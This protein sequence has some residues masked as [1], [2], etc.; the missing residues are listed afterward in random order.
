MN[1]LE[2]EGRLLQIKERKLIDSYGVQSIVVEKIMAKLETKDICCFSGIF[3]AI[4]SSN[5]K[6]A[7]SYILEL[8][9]ISDTN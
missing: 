1:S 5:L 9:Y 7:L 8:E 3:I 6:W 4:S 2:D